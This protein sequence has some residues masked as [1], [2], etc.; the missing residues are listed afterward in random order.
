MKINHS[1]VEKEAAADLKRT[2]KAEAKKLK[3]I[4]LLTQ[5]GKQM[6]HI[7]ATEVDS[8]DDADADAIDDLEFYCIDKKIG[9]P[10]T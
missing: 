6:P 5:K 9:R 4:F 8:K 2:K 7:Q 3:K 1:L 10:T